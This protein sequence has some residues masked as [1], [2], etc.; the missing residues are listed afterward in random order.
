MTEEI[1]ELWFLDLGGSNRATRK[2]SSSRPQLSSWAS[3]NWQKGELQTGRILYK[4][5]RLGLG[6]FEECGAC[7]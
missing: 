2:V 3:P 4:R 1:Q 5:N 6:A 7:Y